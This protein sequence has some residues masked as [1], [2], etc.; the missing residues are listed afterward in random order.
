MCD[1]YTSQK[2]MHI[3]NRQTARVQFQRK[4]PGCDSQGTWR[5]DELIGGK[6]PVAKEGWLLTL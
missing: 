1:T 5:Q 2:A 6:L 3:H 4:I